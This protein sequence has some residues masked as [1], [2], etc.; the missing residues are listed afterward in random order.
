ML[1]SDWDAISPPPP[2]GLASGSNYF[3]LSE[4]RSLATALVTE[5]YLSHTSNP[6]HMTT[7]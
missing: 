3:L 1:T 4:P 6:R 7:N 5:T 2:F